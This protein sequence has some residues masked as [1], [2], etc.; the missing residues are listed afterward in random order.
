MIDHASSPAGQRQRIRVLLADDHVI[1]RAALRALLRRQRDLLVVGEAGRGDDAVACAQATRPDVVLMDLA[2]PGE[3]GIEAT[4]RITQ[5]GLG[6]RVLVLTGLPQEEQLLEALEAGA[7][8]FVEKAGPL[9]DLLRAIRTVMVSR[10]FLCDDAAKLV[11]LQRYRKAGRAADEKAT[12]ERLSAREREVLALVALGLSS[13]EIGRK[14]AVSR[15]TVD[16]YRAR[17]KDRLG[18]K[19]RPELVRFALRSG[20]LQPQ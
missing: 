4:R 12:L 6:A 5:L 19:H 17:L 9:E 13:A 10:L 2:M 1:F 8:G 14:L 18:L 16:G 15:K 11:V 3:G 7:S 20:L